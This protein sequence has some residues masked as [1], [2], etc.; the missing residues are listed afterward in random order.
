MPVKRSGIE[1]I[2]PCPFCGNSDPYW[3]S[4]LIDGTEEHFLM[5]SN[6]GCQG[7]YNR[8]HFEAAMLWNGRVEA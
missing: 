5:C 2:K 3:D 1:E 7:P 6:C 4:V 8:E